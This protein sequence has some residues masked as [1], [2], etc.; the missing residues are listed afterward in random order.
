MSKQREE[1]AALCYCLAWL[2]SC[3]I[4]I[5]VFFR[6]NTLASLTRIALIFTG[7][8]C[9]WTAIVVGVKKLK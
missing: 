3:A 4:I 5:D 8:I 1:L 6:D 7:I 9:F 2:I